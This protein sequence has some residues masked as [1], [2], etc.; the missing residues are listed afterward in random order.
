M[1]KRTLSLRS[2]GWLATYL[3]TYLL[4]TYLRTC[5]SGS[6]GAVAITLRRYQAGIY[7]TYRDEVRGP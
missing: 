6:T 7:W 2:S 1:R 4:N 3:P 5:D